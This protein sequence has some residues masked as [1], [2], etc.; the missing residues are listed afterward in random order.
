MQGGFFMSLD[1]Q[2]LSALIDAAVREAVERTARELTAKHE[3]I[4]EGLRRNR[5]ELLAERKNGEGKKASDNF[6]EWLEG[7]DQRLAKLRDENA[8]LLGK[9]S[10]A[11]AKSPV[12]EHTISRE[13]ARSGERYREAKAAAEKAGVPLRITDDN[14]PPQERR[15]S[16][17][18]YVK[19]ADAGVLYV[20]ADMIRRYGQARCR[21]IAAEQGAST[22]RAFRHADDLPDSVMQAHAQAMV[23]RSNLLGGE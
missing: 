7:I 5:D 23:D 6:D 2:Q 20:N 3:A 1:Q 19:D 15:S 21:E 22:M 8:R 18:K 4:T 13:E 17:V 16:P 9:G 12:T 14:A 11:P 10:E